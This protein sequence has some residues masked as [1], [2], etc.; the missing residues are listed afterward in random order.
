[1]ATSFRQV[2]TWAFSV[3]FTRHVLFCRLSPAMTT[4]LYATKPIAYESLYL[5]LLFTTKRK[6]KNNYREPQTKKNKVCC[7]PQSSVLSGRSTLHAECAART[8]NGTI[9]LVATDVPIFASRADKTFIVFGAGRVA[10]NSSPAPF[11]V[12]V[13]LSSCWQEVYEKSSKTTFHIPPAN[14]I[15]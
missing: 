15:P 7:A 2:V 6:S 13:S 11:H 10:K 14:W 4:A 8:I 9:K 12:F 1:V 5:I 3:A